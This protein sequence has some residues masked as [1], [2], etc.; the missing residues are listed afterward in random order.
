MA[1]CHHDRPL[2][3]P[4]IETCAAHSEFDYRRAK[5]ALGEDGVPFVHASEK[6]MRRI[7]GQGGL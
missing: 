1:L 5:R 6:R 2:I 4:D 7:M 3:Y